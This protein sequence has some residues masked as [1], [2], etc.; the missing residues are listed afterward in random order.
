MSP[1]LVGQVLFGVVGALMVALG[2][3]LWRRR[4]R[5]NHL[6]GLRSPETLGD[7]VVWYQANAVSGLIQVGAGVILLGLALALPRVSGLS[8][9]WYVMI[10]LGWLLTSVVGMCLVLPSIA[11][12]MA[13]RR[14]SLGDLGGSGLGDRSPLP[15]PDQRSCSEPDVQ[16][17]G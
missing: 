3:P 2:L 9:E 16:S 12:R 7:E 4:V 8:A 14:S 6:Y 5:P 13:R 17:V 15:R 1:V 11:R 10:C